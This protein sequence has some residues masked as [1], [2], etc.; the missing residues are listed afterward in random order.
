MPGGSSGSGMCVCAHESE[1]EIDLTAGVR[2]NNSIE[3]KD[4]AVKGLLRR[5]SAILE[6]TLSF[7]TQATFILVC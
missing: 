7:I 4:R 3:V 6:C 5:W 1:R 2:Q